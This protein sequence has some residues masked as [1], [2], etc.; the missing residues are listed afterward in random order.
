MLRTVFALTIVFACA[1]AGA[2]DQ[3]AAAPSPQ[4]NEASTPANPAEDVRLDNLHKPEQQEPKPAESW[5]QKVV[6]EAPN[7]KWFTD[8]CRTCSHTA[9]SNIGIACQPKE[10]TCN[11]PQS[12]AKPEAGPETKPDAKP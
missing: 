11:D 5:W 8:G 12:N 7:C 9:C 10:W 4:A 1:G 3:P 6:R 2:A